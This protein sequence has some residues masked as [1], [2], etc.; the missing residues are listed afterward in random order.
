MVSPKAGSRGSRE[1]QEKQRQEKHVG[2]GRF[3]GHAHP[4]CEHLRPGVG[5]SKP[6]LATSLQRLGFRGCVNTYRD[7]ESDV[8][9][10]PL[11]KGPRGHFEQWFAEE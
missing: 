9:T 1:K 7:S 10:G 11:K 2:H 5:Q 6:A 8:H 3:D 4:M